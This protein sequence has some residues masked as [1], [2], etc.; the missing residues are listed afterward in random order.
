MKKIFAILLFFIIL[1]HIAS[2]QD[3]EGNVAVSEARNIYTGKAFRAFSIHADIF[4]PAMGVITNKDIQ[5]FEIQADINLY[6]KFFPTIEA[7]F[8]NIKTELINRQTYN[9]SS[10]FFRVG[11]NYNLLNNATSD[12]TAKIIRSYPFVGLR[13]SFGAFN[14]QMDNIPLSEDYWTIDK[15]YHFERNDI[16]GG[17]LEIV[18][19]IRVD[20]YRGLTMG[21]N[22]RLKT[23][24]HSPDKAHL[25]WTPGYGFTSGGQFAFNYTIGYTFRTRE[26][27]ERAKPQANKK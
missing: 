27:I 23:A 8:G 22:I 10:S 4:S 7:G 9:S 15:R 16:Y 13:Y 21:W 17:W 6:D 14:Y 3:D 20:I 11:F 1:P 2:A 18:G 24:F 26:E 19:G 12:G 5:T 25:W